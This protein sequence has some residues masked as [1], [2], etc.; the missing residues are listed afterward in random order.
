MTKIIIIIKLLILTNTFKFS[1]NIKLGF[2]FF[3]YSNIFLKIKGI[4]EN[5]I[6]G[7]GSFNVPN[8]IYINRV[9]QNEINYKYFL[10]K[11]II[12]LK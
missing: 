2:H 11:P 5:A 7:Y 8:Y 9:K 6:L 3:Q 1:K 4:G 10:I 12:M